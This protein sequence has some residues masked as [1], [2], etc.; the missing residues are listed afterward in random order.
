MRNRVCVLRCLSCAPEGS[1]QRHRRVHI[2]LSKHQ[3]NRLLKP[4]EL[5]SKYELKLNSLAVRRPVF[6]QKGGS[7]TRVRFYQRGAEVSLTLLL[8]QRP[9]RLSRLMTGTLTTRPGSWQRLAGAFFKYAPVP[10]SGS[11]SGSPSPPASCVMNVAASLEGRAAGRSSAAVGTVSGSR[12]VVAFR[13]K[14]LK[15]LLGAFG[16]LPARPDSLLPGH[17]A[18]PSLT[19]H[20]AG[21]SPALRRRGGCCLCRDG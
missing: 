15:E 21:R 4:L 2:L 8:K 18:L 20:R 10:K 11:L 7:D 13:L 5:S 6:L 1:A 9:W 14:N 3:V 16:P 12:T 19:A 17:G